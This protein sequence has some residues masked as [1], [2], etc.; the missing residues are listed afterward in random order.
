VHKLGMTHA[1]QTLQTRLQPSDNTLEQ[2]LKSLVRKALEEDLQNQ[3]DITSTAIIAA[4]ARGK[5]RMIAKQDGVLS[6]LGAVQ[7]VFTECAPDTNLR[8]EKSNGD[9]IHNGDVICTVEGNI[10]QILLAE[11]TALNFTGHLSGVATLTARY[12]AAVKGTNAKIMATRKTLPG[13]RCLQKQA[14]IDGGG[15]PHRY[16]LYDA[17]LIKDNHLEAMQN[18]IEATMQKVVEYNKDKHPVILELESLS[19]IET[20]LALPENLHPDRVLLDN[21]NVTTMKRAVDMIAGRFDTEASGG[22][23]LE[24]IRDYALTGVDA[25]SCGALTHS[26][27]IFDLSMEITQ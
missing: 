3:S 9:T 18:D 14:V 10:R 11:R 25:I 19:Q 1:S 15:D 20:L 2:E 23:T 5:A 16:G 4:D 7:A 21:M 6:G 27:T 13:L 8:L 12:V 22:I 26:A 17:I 24:T